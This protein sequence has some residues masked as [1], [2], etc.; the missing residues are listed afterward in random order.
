MK[1][2][3]LRNILDM[4]LVAAGAVLYAISFNLF[5][6]PNQINAGGLT[7][8]MMVVVELTGFGTVGALTIVCN[9]PLFLL[10]WKRLGRKFFVG[11]LIGMLSCNTAIDLLAPI[12]PEVTGEPLLA[13]LYGGALA[14]VGLGLVFSRGAST[15]GTDI[16]ARLAKSRLQNFSMGKVMLGLDLLVV[17]LTGIVFRDLNKVLY[18]MVTLYVS[19]I[20]LDAVVYG[21]DYSK[22]AL[23]I[24]DKYEEISRMIGQQMDRGATLLHGKGSYTNQD[25]MVILVAFK[26]KQLAELKRAVSEIDPKAFIIVQDAHQVQGEGFSRYS[27]DAL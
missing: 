17:T 12:L 8:L 4:V 25:K 11:S 19:S 23:I 9:I 3:L 27:K 10:G 18:C 5:M 2:N 22:V 7:G 20:T 15:G 21:F 26:K 13:C 1:K 16:I 24:S 6:E 14:G